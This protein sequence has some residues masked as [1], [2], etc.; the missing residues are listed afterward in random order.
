MY[1]TMVTL[2]MGNGRR[3]TKNERQKSQILTL[4]V[5]HQYSE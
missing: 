4:K 5:Q 3:Q 1:G 2:K